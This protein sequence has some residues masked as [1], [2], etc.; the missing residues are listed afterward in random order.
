VPQTNP[1]LDCTGGHAIRF[2]MAG[3]RVRIV[4]SM[5]E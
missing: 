1:K 3:V 2:L 4:V 5:D